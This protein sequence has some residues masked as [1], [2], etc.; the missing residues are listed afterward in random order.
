MIPRTLVFKKAIS[1]VQL[2]DLFTKYVFIIKHKRTPYNIFFCTVLF[3]CHFPQVEL[4]NLLA[5]RQ[6]FLEEVLTLEK[7]PPLSFHSNFP[8][9]DLFNH[10][11]NAAMI[12][13]KRCTVEC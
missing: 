10:F 4:C 6:N 12:K 8:K 2:S 13:F 5:F 9:V 1:Q 11:A 7:H 3:Q